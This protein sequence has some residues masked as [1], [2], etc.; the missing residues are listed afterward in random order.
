MEMNICLFEKLV[1]L[2][3]EIFV[4]PQFISVKTQLYSWPYSWPRGCCEPE[5]Q[6]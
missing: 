2:K 6:C 4:K 3:D 5:V 1:K